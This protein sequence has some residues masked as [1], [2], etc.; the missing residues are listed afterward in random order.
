[1][2]PLPPVTVIL[3]LS[4]P[5]PAQQADASPIDVAGRQLVDDAYRNTLACL[6]QL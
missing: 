4:L 6:N 5:P 1:M 2:P 3:R